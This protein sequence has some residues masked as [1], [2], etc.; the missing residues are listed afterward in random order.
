MFFLIFLELLLSPFR[1]DKGLVWDKTVSTSPFLKQMNL[2]PYGNFWKCGGIFFFTFFLLLLIRFSWCENPRTSW[3][4]FTRVCLIL[5]T[6]EQ[7]LGH[8]F[9]RARTKGINLFLRRPDVNGMLLAKQ[10]QTKLIIRRRRGEGRG[11]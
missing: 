4:F 3:S 6:E 9:K 11:E 2:S 1:Q 10:L 8:F 5:G 7:H